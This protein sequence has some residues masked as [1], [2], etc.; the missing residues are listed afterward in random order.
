MADVLLDFNAL[1]AGDLLSDQYSDQGVRIFSLNSHNPAM[2]F[3][4]ARPTGG[5]W[6]LKTSNMSKVLILSEDGDQSD[7]DDNA[8]GGTLVFE[9]ESAASVDSLRVLDTEEGGYIKCFDAEGDLIKKV[10]IPEIC[11][12][13]QATVEIDAEGVYRMEVTVC[14]SAAIDD[15]KYSIDLDGDDCDAPNGIVEG[16]DGDDLID[17]NYTGDPQGDMIDAGDAILPGQG[18]DDDIVYAGGGDDTVHGGKGDDTIY[19]DRSLEYGP[20]KITITDTDAS[21][22][23]KLFAYTIDPETGDVSN[24]VI[25]SE[26]TKA[27]VGKTFTY[28]VDPCGIMGIGI[29]SPQGTFVSS[30]YGEN[31]DLNPDGKVHTK[32]LGEYPDGSVKLGFEDLLCLGDKDF[33]DVVVKVD[34]GTSGATLDN[35]HYDYTSSGPAIDDSATGDDT[36]YGDEGNDTLYGQK[37]N[38][39]LIGGEGRDTSYG[40]DGD[41]TIIGDGDLPGGGDPDIMYGGDDRDTFSKISIGDKIFGGDGG[42]DCDTLDLRGSGPIRVT[43]LVTDS[44]GNGFDGTVEFLDKPGGHVIGTAHFEN[45]E[46]IIPCFTPGTLIA[47]PNGERPVEELTV[48]D[49]VITRDNGIQEIR[50]YGQKL[51]DYE[52]LSE[53]RHLQPILIRKGAFADGLPER[54]MIVSPNHRMLVA[55]DLTALYFEEHEVLVAAKH[56]I[57]NRSVHRLQMLQTTYIHF[58]FDQHEVV[59]ANGAWTES[60]QPGDHSLR[61]LGNAQRNELFTVFPELQTYKGQR[62]YSAARRTL[63]EHEAVLLGR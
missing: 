35:K 8:S 49:K 32:G 33:N 42:I 9:F 4:T 27:D 10:W 34:L 25:L 21:F 39:T 40:G 60:F 24:L 1:S 13:E 36:L 61:G 56:L 38:D 30:A 54:D 62:K 19:G 55:N 2:I 28:N 29:I 46:K 51:I 18:P 31:V 23:N 44:D 37:G 22:T 59:L 3:D 58:M 15:V 12:N 26:N 20:A 43:D 6:D 14:G 16:T 11:N 41:D 52:Q 63:K 47:T 57:N 50:W 7:P 5:D 53:E 17:E 45:I 48:G